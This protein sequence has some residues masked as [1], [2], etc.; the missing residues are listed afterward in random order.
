MVYLLCLPNLLDCKNLSL[1]GRITEGLEHLFRNT[2][3][4]E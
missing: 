4:Q 1:E 3:F 2:A